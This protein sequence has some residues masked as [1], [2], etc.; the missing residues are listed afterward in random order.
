MAYQVH[1]KKVNIN[2]INNIHKFILNGIK[3]DITFILKVSSNSSRKRLLKRK[4][5]NR[6]DNFADSF[7]S[8]AKEMA[9]KDPNRLVRTRAVEF[10]GLTGAAEPLPL[11]MKVLEDCADPIE[12]NLILNTVV[13][14]R[15]GHG[16]KLTHDMVKKAKWSKLK[17]LVERRIE[18]LTKE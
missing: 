18:Y 8:K 14:L 9:A 4:S 11:I 2:F 17:G 1:G 12:A 7:Y 3:P 13:L 5:K 15:D 10:L 16:M 6:Y